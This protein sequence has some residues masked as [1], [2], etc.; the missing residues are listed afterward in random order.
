MM[1]VIS[2]SDGMWERGEEQGM[3]CSIQWY[4]FVTI[5][6]IITKTL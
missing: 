1:K 3:F 6:H 2:E 4:Y 5:G